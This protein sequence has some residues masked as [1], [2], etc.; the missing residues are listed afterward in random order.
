MSLAAD[1]VA[2][3]HALS[4]VGSAGP[5]K[6]TT[7][8]NESALNET[9]LPQVAT[10]AASLGACNHDATNTWSKHRAFR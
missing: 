7:S 3:L 5:L 10:G 4:L 8:N 6:G 2:K 1:T 9:W